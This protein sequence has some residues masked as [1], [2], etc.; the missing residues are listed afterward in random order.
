[1]QARCLHHKHLNHYKSAIPLVILYWSCFTAI[2]LI[3]PPLSTFRWLPPSSPQAVTRLPA[4][5]A[6]S[7]NSSMSFL[8]RTGKTACG[9][10]HSAFVRATMDLDDDPGSTGGHA[11]D[12]QRR[13]QIPLAG[14]VRGIDEDRQVASVPG[15]PGPPTRPG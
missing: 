7:R 13:N 8:N 6:A 1:M 12:R 5:W 2:Q 15:L 3:H 10:S 14:R 9:P 4:S 11:G